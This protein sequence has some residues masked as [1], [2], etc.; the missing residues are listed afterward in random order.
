MVDAHTDFI[1]ET[2]IHS[3]CIPLQVFR[4]DNLLSLGINKYIKWLGIKFFIA[5]HLT[6]RMD[7]WREYGISI[8]PVE[9]I[10][11]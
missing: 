7:G 3:I 11:G 5:L 6:M 10:S 2:L 8:E 1:C 4:I 9:S